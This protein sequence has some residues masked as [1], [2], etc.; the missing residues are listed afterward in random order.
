M[1]HRVLFLDFDGVL[2]RTCPTSATEPPTGPKV[3]GVQTRNG[4]TWRWV[5]EDRYVLLVHDLVA[6]ARG[7]MEASGAVVV[8]T[9]D[10]IAL[11]TLE[12]IIGLLEAAGWPD[13]P[14]IGTTRPG[15]SWE[16]KSNKT[17]VSDWIRRHGEPDRWAAAVP[18]RWDD[19]GRRRP[20]V[21]VHPRRGLTGIDLDE[22][23]MFLN[24][25]APRDW[26]DDVFYRP[27]PL[28]SAS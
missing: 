3:A 8:L 27:D 17:K 13:P 4:L 16:G 28:E 12:E 21:E 14:V 11:L 7:V 2:N 5:T 24:S 19:Q 23:R 15:L 25:S 10:W 6:N 22:T 26:M 9:T 18:P 1:T 20:I